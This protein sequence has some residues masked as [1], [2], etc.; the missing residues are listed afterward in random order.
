[1]SPGK[2]GGK[3]G[4]GDERSNGNFER[5]R[6][7]LRKREERWK[8]NFK[9]KKS[10]PPISSGLS[11]FSAPPFPP[12]LCRERGG[13]V[14]RRRRERE[15]GKARRGGKPSEKKGHTTAHFRK[16]LTA[17]GQRPSTSLSRLLLI[18]SFAE[19]RNKQTPPPVTKKNAF[20]RARSNTHTKPFPPFF[21]CVCVESVLFF[22]WSHSEIR[23]QT[24]QRLLPPPRVLLLGCGPSH[25]F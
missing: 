2:R 9:K 7:L 22:L 8:E 23:E 15:C 5:K 14:G 12:L 19:L 3:E 17:Y 25:L 11:L 16:V 10:T 13:K 4:A 20:L 6:T 18:V 1:M 24:I 21:V